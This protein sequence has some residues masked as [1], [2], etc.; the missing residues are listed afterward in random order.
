MSL[1]DSCSLLGDVCTES[2]K[3]NLHT[4]EQTI[5]LAI[6]LAREGREGRKIGTMFV[7]SDADEVLK[8]SR[9]LILDPLWHHPAEDKRI[10]DSNLRETV[11]ELAQLDGAFVISDDG[12]VL[13]GTRYISASAD[14]IDVPLG[15]IVHV[16]VLS[17]GYVIEKVMDLLYRAVRRHFGHAVAMVAISDY[18]RQQLVTAAEVPPQRIVL[19]R[20]G[21]DTKPYRPIDREYR[22]NI[23]GGD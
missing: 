8:R 6:E 14:G 5:T 20:T 17:R 16:C 4:L 11:K 7:V 19:M 3:V 23:R 22:D 12:V 10:D 13:S 15:V 21:V 18:V 1:A 2:R 9:C